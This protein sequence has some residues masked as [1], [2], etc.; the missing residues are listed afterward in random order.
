MQNQIPRQS[1]SDRLRVTHVVG[2]LQTGGLEK[3]LVEFAR[4]VDR[5]RIHLRFVC[6]GSTGPI[7]DEIADCGWVVSCLGFQPGLRGR[8]VARLAREF[9]RTRTHIIHTHNNAPLIYGG[10]AARLAGARAVIQTRHGQSTGTSRR[11]RFAFRLASFFAARVVCVSEDSRMLSAAEGIS[12]RR[13]TVIRNGID[14]TKF[15]FTGPAPGGPMVMVGRLVPLKGVDT[16]LH[17]VRRVIQQ[18]PGFRLE[19]AGDGVARPALKDLA[20]ELNLEGHVRFLGN[21]RDI[22]GLLARASSLVLPSLSEGISLTL[23]EAM[24][25]GLPVPTTQV[26]GSPEV[27]EDGVTGRIVAPANPAEL[28]SAILEIGTVND[29]TCAMGRAGRARVERLFDVR[30]MVA[31]YES[32]Y[33]QLANRSRG[34][35]EPARANESKVVAA[36]GR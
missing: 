6:L 20:R 33:R 17:A 27:V 5:S 28:A 16:L 12:P 34:A 29:R 15:A 21:I 23:L 32:L 25:C 13:L 14:T 36:V 4:H 22:P 1:G 31:E 26:G 24:A 8:V 30:K 11:H 10:P 19:I 7:A 9:A 3:L 18:Q 2:Q 35:V